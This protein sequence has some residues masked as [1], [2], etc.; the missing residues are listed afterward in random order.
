MA[1]MAAAGIAVVLV[2]A[3]TYQPGSPP[4]ADRLLGSG[5]CVVLLANGDAAE[6]NCSEPHDAVVDRIV[7]FGD[8][9][10]FGTEPH[11]D[12]QGLGVAC[13]RRP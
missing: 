6:V 8:V 12:Q 13:T 7:A 11:R 3:A 9:C 10:P 4:P 1:G 2:G 5:S